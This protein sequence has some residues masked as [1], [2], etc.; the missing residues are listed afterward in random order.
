ML[1]L[2]VRSGNSALPFLCAGTVLCRGPYLQCVQK[3]IHRLDSLNNSTTSTSYFSFCAFVAFRTFASA[4]F[5]RILCSY[6]FSL[7]FPDGLLLR[8]HQPR[9]LGLFLLWRLLALHQRGHAFRQL[10]PVRA[11]HSAHRTFSL[12]NRPICPHAHQCLGRTCMVAQ[13]QQLSHWRSLFRKC[14]FRAAHHSPLGFASA[15][16]SSSSFRIATAKDSLSARKRFDA[17]MKTCFASS[18]LEQASCNSKYSSA[19]FH[20]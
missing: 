18:M 12:A 2:V 6:A 10:P 19:S 5:R 15:S 14:S 3:L 17:P 9:F 13:P 20:S 8:R 11:N 16:A 1:Y 7:G 4:P